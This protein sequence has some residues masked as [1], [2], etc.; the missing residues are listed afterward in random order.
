MTVLVMQDVRKMRGRGTRTI[1]VIRGISLSIERG[2]VVLLKGPSG[3]G[4]TTLLALAAGLL[5]PDQG[6][7]CL[8]GQVLGELDPEQSRQVRA[9]KV[10]FVFQ[11]SNLFAHLSALDNVLVSAALAGM[12]SAT[13]MEEAIGLLKSL[14]M[15]AYADRYPSELSGGQEQRIALARALVH[16]PALVLADEPTGN[17]DSV[18]GR[19][20]TEALFNMARSRNAAVLVATHDSRLE[21]IATRDLNI[22]DGVIIP[23]SP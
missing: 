19:A 3:S 16:R 21:D 20:V 12:D 5:V 8:D 18:S 1:P 17:L 9:R 4:K 7:V 23:D 11:R 13:A 6:R 10:G 15:D 14:A 22:A 2:E